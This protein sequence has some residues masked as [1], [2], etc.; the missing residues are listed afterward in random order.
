[1]SRIEINAGGRHIIVDHD[2][3]LEPLR[4]AALSLFEATATARDRLGPATGFQ[5]VEQ[6]GP[7]HLPMG[8]G[9][10][11]VPPDPATAGGEH[12]RG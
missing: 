3:E 8:H 9:A 12:R 7:A 1:M 6:S 11:G 5:V 4:L 10:Y 2:G